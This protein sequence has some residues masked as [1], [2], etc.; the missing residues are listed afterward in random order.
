MTDPKD[1]LVVN[2]AESPAGGAKPGAKPAGAV[3]RAKDWVNERP[4]NKAI[5]GASL[6]SLLLLPC[7][8]AP[9]AVASQKQSA[10][11]TKVPDWGAYRSVGSKSVYLD[12]LVRRPDEHARAAL[13][14]RPPAGRPGPIL[15]AR[16]RPLALSPPPPARAARVPLLPGPSS[17][18]QP[19][20]PLPLSPLSPKPN[21]QGNPDSGATST[22]GS[23]KLPP[24]LKI[25]NFGSLSEANATIKVPKGSKK[26]KAAAA[27]KYG[28]E[29]PSAFV[30]VEGDQFDKDCR[31][32]YPT[33]FNAFELFILAAE[34]KKDAVDYAFRQARLMGM[35]SAR[36]WAHSIHRALPFQ[37]APGQYD[38]KGLAALDYVLDSASRNGIQLILSFVDNW[39]YYNGV[40]QFVDWCGPGRT[41]ER[42]VD[43]GG[44]TDDSKWGA[45]QKR[46][47]SGRN[48]H[49]F[50]DERCQQM[51]MDHVKF[52][53][54]R[55]NSI[56]GK[57]YKSDP[58]ILAWNLINEPRC[59]VWVTPDCPQKLDAW[60]SKMAKYVKSVDPNHL[61]SAGSEGFFGDSDPSWLG[62]NPGSWATQTG[63]DFL[64]NTKDMD[65]AV[66]HAWPDNWMM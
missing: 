5:A 7:I 9:A 49:F 60:Y 46:Y 41:M 39:K 8:I 31:P 4:R 56:N 54:S 36:T 58:T 66:A 34:G 38:D 22:M 33:G 35:T 42:P 19:A 55:K 11:R 57:A 61:V 50:S 40:S 48:S 23:Y 12:P 52:I 44:D 27:G 2:I 1:D 13:L 3:Q 65:F 28:T 53:V 59:E 37:T 62:K 15:H 64:A 45:E 14:P 47:E 32:F 10:R 18:A 20:P 16:A 21:R 26:R 6:A 63:Q 30:A 29:A 24:G 25:P 17:H 51:Y 43:A